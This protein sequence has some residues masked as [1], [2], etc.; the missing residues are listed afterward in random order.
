MIQEIEF[1]SVKIDSGVYCFA[2]CTLEVIN[3]EN[4]IVVVD[5]DYHGDDGRQ[6]NV[7]P[8]LREQAAE[9]LE[10]LVNDWASDNPE[11]MAKL[12]DFDKICLEEKNT[13]D[14]DRI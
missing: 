9:I 5:C 3:G 8:Q 12:N 4:V 14:S 13:F 7:S 6:L 2:N 11:T 1:D 10:S